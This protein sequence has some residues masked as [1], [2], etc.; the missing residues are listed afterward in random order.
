[1]KNNLIKC[2]YVQIITEDKIILKFLLFLLFENDNEKKD[3]KILLAFLE[4]R[5]F[6]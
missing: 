3:E 2:R 5:N 6:Y 1:M 4:I